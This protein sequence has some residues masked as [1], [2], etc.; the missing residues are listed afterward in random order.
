MSADR[1]SELADAGGLAWAVGRCGLSWQFASSVLP[2][3]RCWGEL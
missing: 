3:L 1:A 2:V